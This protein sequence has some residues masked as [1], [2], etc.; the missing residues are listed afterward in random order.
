MA[1]NSNRALTAQMIDGISSFRNY[2]TNAYARENINGWAVYA[3]AAQS[4]PV[5]GT[6][7]SP[8]LTLGVNISSPL[9]FESDFKITKGSS[10]LQGEGV[11]YD[12]TIDTADKNK[13]IGICFDYS[14]SANFVTGT[15]SDLQVFMYDVTNAQLIPLQRNALLVN[16]SKFV[17]TFQSSTSTSYRLIMHVATT[18]ANAWTFNFTSV[19]V[20]VADTLF[21]TNA[22]GAIITD[23]QSYT[24]TFTG[25]GTATNIS[26]FYRRVGDNIHIRGKF[27]S[28]T[29]TA[30]EARVSLPNGLLSD[31]TKVASIREAGLM[32]IDN[33]SSAAPNIATSLIESNVGYLTFGYRD[34]SS[35]GLTKQNGNGFANSTN[36]SLEAILPISQWTSETAIAN[37]GI[38]VMSQILASGT[39]VTSTPAALGEYRSRYKSGGSLTDVA[40]TAPPSASDGLLIY[41]NVPGNTSSGTS[42][43]ITVYDIF[44]GK[45]KSVKPQ[46][47]QSSGRTGVVTTDFFFTSGIDEGILY[48]YDPTTGVATIDGNYF[49]SSGNTTRYAGQIPA[50]A[51]NVVSSLYF[52]LIVA[53][54]EFQIQLQGQENQVR[55]Y[56]GNGFGST[57]TKIV[58][59]SNIQKNVGTAITYADSST[60]GGSFTINE[61][62]VY[63]IS[64]G[65]RSNSSSTYVGVTLNS[66]AL[67]T[68]VWNSAN[69]NFR[70]C[71]SDTP[72]AGFS[73]ACSAT[74][75]CQPGDVL[76]VHGDGASGVNDQFTWAT[77]CKS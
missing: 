58:R 63:S 9:R 6:G 76:R 13:N 47:Y 53:D 43:Q 57:N 48:S 36:Y 29:T 28:G 31:A 20:G 38:L 73:T 3:N 7:G 56:T 34:G 69:N 35:A 39:R 23:E 70:L 55:V 40:P 49:T 14:G 68:D 54:N 22:F 46:Y 64:C 15:N 16:N 60:L 4:T 72:G 17:A 30:T 24:P 27:T 1:N 41:G 67:T 11:S 10:N 18:N 44:V 66:T 50:T 21:G 26:F 19:T 61:A 62:G 59:F 75:Y 51:G 74:V 37:S 52:D 8:T 5:D 12:F 77:I 25:W 71:L 2:I 32:V 33:T 42:G 65:I 45:N